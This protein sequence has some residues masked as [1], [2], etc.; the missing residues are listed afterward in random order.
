MMEKINCPKCGE[1][2]ELE[3]RGAAVMEKVEIDVAETECP[4]CK[5]KFVRPR[6]KG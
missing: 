4:K 3:L 6:K 5:A 2:F 1:E